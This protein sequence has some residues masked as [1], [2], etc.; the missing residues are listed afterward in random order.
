MAERID[1]SLFVLFVH[2]K[3]IRIHILGVLSQMLMKLYF[4]SIFFFLKF[5]LLD[6]A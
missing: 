2:R 1:F 6:V 4:H 5:F 3:V